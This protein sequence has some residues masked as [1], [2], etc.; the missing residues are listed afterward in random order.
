M[1]TLL[2]QR[3]IALTLTL[4]GAAIRLLP[5]A[6]NFA[7]VGAVSL[8]AGGRLSGWSAF[9]V[10]LTLM[11]ATDTLLTLAMGYQVFTTVTP[12]VYGSFLISVLIGTRLRKS[13]QPWR[14]GT[15]VL[16]SSL[17]FFLIT[18]FGLWISP[19]SSYPLTLSGLATCYV[20]GIPYFGRTLVSDLLFSGL[21]FGAHASIARLAFPAGRKPAVLSP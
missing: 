14:I 17:Q 4:L 7:P 19:F 13:N 1:K 8:F 2:R 21:L 15:A 6:P 9:A 5:H 18:N 10:P 3:P 12:F 16:V 11:A 20:S